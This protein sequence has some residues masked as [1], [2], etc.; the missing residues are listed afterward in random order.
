MPPFDRRAG[1]GLPAHFSLVTLAV[2]GLF[3]ASARAQSSV[4]AQPPGQLQQITVTGQVESETATSPVY[5]MVAKRTSTGLK[6]DT[7]ILEAPQSV[8]VVTREQME[9]QGAKG[10]DE[11]VR[12]T[13][14]Q[15]GAPS[16]RTRAATGCWC[17][18]S[19][20]RNTSTACRCPTASGPV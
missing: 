4:T 10:L 7:D 5:G 16:A 9:L 3:A 13:P 11:V 17:A 8:S 20:P 15:W 14:A 19:S 18:A 2:L 1:A 6:T 12:Y